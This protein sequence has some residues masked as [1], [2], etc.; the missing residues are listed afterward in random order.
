MPETVESREVASTPV[1]TPA[2]LCAGQ[3]ALPKPQAAEFG[4][5]M[6]VDAHT[7]CVL[8]KCFQHGYGLDLDDIED[9]MRERLQ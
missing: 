1:S 9:W 8:F 2:W 5:Y 3:V 6:V 4:S 7:R